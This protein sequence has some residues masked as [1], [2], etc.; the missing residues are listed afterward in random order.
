MLAVCYAAMASQVS[1][2]SGRNQPVA[3]LSTFP[4]VKLCHI[5]WNLDPS[6]RFL[7]DSLG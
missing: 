2:A 6:F 3:A 7:T 4:E 5:L 1:E